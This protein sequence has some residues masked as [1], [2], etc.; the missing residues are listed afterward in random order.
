[1]AYLHSPS[2]GCTG[3]Y[4]PSTH[5]GV[6]LSGV[7]PSPVLR[8]HRRLITFNPLRGFT[9]DLDLDLD[10]DLNLDLPERSDG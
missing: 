8:L 9:T 2:S 1:M 7:S 6:D 4:L 5:F 10:L 3:G